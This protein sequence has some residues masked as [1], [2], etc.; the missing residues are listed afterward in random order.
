MGWDGEALRRGVG[1][2]D[3]H[4]DLQCVQTCPLLEQT[5]RAMQRALAGPHLP[6]IT[7]G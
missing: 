4:T 6:G 2:G 5:G 3:G 1:W 7:P